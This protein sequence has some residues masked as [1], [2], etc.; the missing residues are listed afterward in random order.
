MGLV[1]LAHALTRIDAAR[2]EWPSPIRERAEV[3]QRVV[4][5]FDSLMELSIVYQ[6]HMILQWQRH[7]SV[8]RFIDLV[9]TMCLYLPMMVP[10]FGPNIIVLD[11]IMMPKYVNHYIPRLNKL[12]YCFVADS[13][14]SIRKLPGEPPGRN[15]NT[16][17]MRTNKK[18]WDEFLKTH[19]H[20]CGWSNSNIFKVDA[21]FTW[22]LCDFLFFNHNGRCWLNDRNISH[23]R[24]QYRSSLARH[25]HP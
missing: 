22:Q 6:L 4:T 10:S 15:L 16:M 3:R 7:I 1:V 9:L 23:S 21:A 14:L 11:H 12:P 5:G 8:I 25:I 13:A 20:R 19:T 24:W 17:H 2:I 18:R